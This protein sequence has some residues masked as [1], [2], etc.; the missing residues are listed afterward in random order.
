MRDIALNVIKGDGAVLL[1]NDMIV[2]LSHGNPLYT[3]L[4]SRFRSAGGMLDPGT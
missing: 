4:T 3:S 1:Q 2:M